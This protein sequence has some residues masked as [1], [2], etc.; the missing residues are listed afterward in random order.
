MRNLGVN[1]KRKKKRSNG[2]TERTRG[3][4]RKRIAQFEPDEGK[5]ER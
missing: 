1:K 2:R 5:E 4:K 3:R